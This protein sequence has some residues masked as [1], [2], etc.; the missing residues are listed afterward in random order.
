MASLWMCQEDIKTPYDLMIDMKDEYQNA[1]YRRRAAHIMLNNCQ[2]LDLQFCFYLQQ[3]IEDE[4]EHMH[5][6]EEQY[7]YIMKN[8]S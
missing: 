8:L 1:R 5:D 2:N 4:T 7:K 6:I 3:V